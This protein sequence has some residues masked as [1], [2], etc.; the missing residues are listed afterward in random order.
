MSDE[1]QKP[2]RRRWLVV[3]LLFVVAV[4]SWW[5]WPRGDAR[6]VGKWTTVHTDNMKIDEHDLILQP[7]GTGR[8]QEKGGGTGYFRWSFESDRLVIG[9]RRG[10]VF[11]DAMHMLAVWLNRFGVSFLSYESKYRVSNMTPDSFD[12]ELDRG[13]AYGDQ[14]LRKYRR[15]PD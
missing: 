11:A 10:G 8:I 6:F 2:K 5:F 9:S 4:I 13:G 15:V 3:V 7:N 14:L 12:M 1:P